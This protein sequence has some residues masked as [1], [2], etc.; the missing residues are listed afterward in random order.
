MVKGDIYLNKIL[1]GCQPAS[2]Q[3]SCGDESLTPK[4]RDFERAKFLRECFKNV[5]VVDKN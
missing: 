5:E 2:L 3:N 1:I 4:Q